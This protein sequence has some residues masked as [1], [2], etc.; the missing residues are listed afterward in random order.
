MPIATTID[1]ND[2]RKNQRIA[3]SLQLEDAV[4][5]GRAKL[6]LSLIHDSMTQSI[7]RRRKTGSFAKCRSVGRMGMISS[8][9]AM[10]TCDSI[11]VLR[12]SGSYALP[13]G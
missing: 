13:V 4:T 3:T 5:V 11:R 7:L 10:P 8:I 9:D 6:P 12:F 2:S 1:A